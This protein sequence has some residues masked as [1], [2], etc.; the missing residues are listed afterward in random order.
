MATCGTSRAAHMQKLL[1]R[2]P[3]RLA[4]AGLTWVNPI[5]EHCQ[6]TAEVRNFGDDR[7]VLAVGK[8]LTTGQT[9][10]VNW[11]Q[12]LGRAKVQSC[13][14]WRS[15]FLVVLS[16]PLQDLRKDVRV[17][18]SGGGT[19]YWWD[20]SRG[21]RTTNVAVRNLSKQ[22]VQVLSPVRLEVPQAVR[23]S[24]ETWDCVGWTRYCEPAGEDFRIGI[25]WT[26]RPSRKGSPRSFSPVA[27]PAR[28]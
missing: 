6:V 28:L 3:A 9:V 22:G 26:E 11:N 16:C 1:Q 18:V 10:G 21:W 4:A 20:Q 17:A 14:P 8:P 13:Q 2:D 19:L 23:L 25:E 7:M 27:A 15:E 5:G 12:R 24:G